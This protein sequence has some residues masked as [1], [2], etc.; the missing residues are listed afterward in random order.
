MKTRNFLVTFQPA[1]GETVATMRVV[2]AWSSTGQTLTQARAM[3]AENFRAAAAGV[4]GAGS[5][6][7]CE[8]ST[9]IL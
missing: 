6:S 1:D 9:R 2:D 5:F 8:Q 3:W 4:Y 7:V